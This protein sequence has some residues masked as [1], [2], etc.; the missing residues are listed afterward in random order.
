MKLPF[1]LCLVLLLGQLLGQSSME[2]VYQSSGSVAGSCSSSSDCDNDLLCY[3]LQFTPENSGTITS[4]TTAFFVECTAAN[5]GNGNPISANAACIMS[6][7]SDQTVDCNGSGVVLI[8]SSGNSGTTAIAAGVPV[9]LHQICLDLSSGQSVDIV[10]DD[11][12]D[13]SVSI[14]RSGGAGPIDELP[15][16]TTFTASY[17]SICALLA[18]ELSSFVATPNKQASLLRWTTSTEIDNDYFSIEWST[19]GQQFQEI[20][21][22]QGAGNSYTALNYEFVHPAPALGT[23]YYRLKA[24]EFDGDADYSAIRLVQ[25]EATKGELLL[26]PNPVHDQ[27][28][29]NLSNTNLANS[30]SLQIRTMAGQLVL[31][32]PNISTAELQAIDLSTLPTGAYVVLL[33]SGEEQLLERFV[34][35]K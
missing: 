9:L 24:I 6:D 32:N 23:N 2:W 33:E 19:N 8:N 29:V 21:K 22:V 18:V 35:M 28:S 31:Q 13:L 27:L 15:A 4:Y 5:N 20:G 7:M 10:E 30:Y 1:V 14:D 26:F 12:T 17:N 3:N 11:F 34:K 25:F 16:Y